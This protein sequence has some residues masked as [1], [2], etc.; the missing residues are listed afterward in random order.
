MSSGKAK[1][2]IAR[3]TVTAV[4]NKSTIRAL[5]LDAGDDRSQEITLSAYARQKYG[6]RREIDDNPA[7]VW[8]LRRS[9]KRSVRHSTAWFWASP[10]CTPE[11]A[12]PPT[13]LAGKHLNDWVLAFMRTSR[14]A[15]A[16]DHVYARGT[17]GAATRS[18]FRSRRGAA[19]RSGFDQARCILSSAVLKITRV[20]GPISNRARRLRRN[21]W[22]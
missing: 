2:L 5:K 4:G 7:G 16:D 22:Q 9:A 12:P 17:S 8:T 10:L 20:G 3:R 15:R 21:S 1:S 14:L 19:I 18:R 6:D 13:E 11:Q